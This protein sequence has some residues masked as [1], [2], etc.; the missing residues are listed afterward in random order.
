MFSSAKS[1]TKIENIQKMALRF[2]LDDYTSSYDEIL[3]KANKPSMD[4]RI[5]RKL[6]IEIY[7]TLNNLNPSFMKEYICCSKNQQTAS[8]SIQTES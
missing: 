2:M 3:I 8:N 4:L 1:F 6:C 5:K 7:K